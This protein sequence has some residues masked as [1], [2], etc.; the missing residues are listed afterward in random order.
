M[1]VTGTK[2]DRLQTSTCSV[3]VL[4]EPRNIIVKLQDRDLK[5]E[6]MR[7]SGAG[8]QVCEGKT[9]IFLRVLRNLLD[10]YLLFIHFLV[11][12]L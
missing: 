10:A 8:G 4:P 1:P 2:N 3:A 5:W 6:Y 11:E 9:N 12:F 7:A